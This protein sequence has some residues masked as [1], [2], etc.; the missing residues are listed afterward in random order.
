G[1]ETRVTVPP[2][3][4]R[5]V[6]ARAS[7][8][9]STAEIAWLVAVSWSSRCWFWTATTPTATAT[10]RQAAATRVPTRGHPRAPGPARPVRAGT[11]AAA[12]PDTRPG[13]RRGA[14]TPGRG[15]SPPTQT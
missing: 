8:A 14:G 4:A 7:G 3:L 2:P 15:L 10:A 9:D 1:A 12:T 6:V 11:G 13:G 5:A